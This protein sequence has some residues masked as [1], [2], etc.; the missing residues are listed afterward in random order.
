VPRKTLH[1]DGPFNDLASMSVD[2]RTPVCAAV[3]E[4]L[5]SASNLHVRRGGRDVL[6]EINL[7]VFAGDVIGVLGL[8]GAGKSTLLETLLGFHPPSAGSVELFM[9]P[10]RNLNGRGKQRIGFVPQ[11]DELMDGLKVTQQIG[12]IASFYPNWDAEL[13]D[14]LVASWDLPMK[15]RID[16]LSCGQRQKL[17]IVLALASRPDLLV[18]DEP[19]ASLDPL[20]RAQFLAEMAAIAADTRRALLFSSHIVSD[21]QGLVNGIWIVDQGRLLWQGRVEL[22]AERFHPDSTGRID[23][24]QAFRQMVG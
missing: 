16:Q 14:R 19:V 5:V 7:S 8:N 24:A 12:L 3:P 17:S 4:A 22:L 21:L 15:R 23:L 13:V 9:Q 1:A 6:E 11:R 20:A 2:A 18:L 10:V